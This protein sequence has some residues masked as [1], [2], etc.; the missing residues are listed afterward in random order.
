MCS[1]SFRMKVR[2]FASVVLG[3][4]DEAIEQRIAGCRV[5]A[6]LVSLLSLSGGRI[7]GHANGPRALLI[8]R[9]EISHNGHGESLGRDKMG[10]FDLYVEGMNGRAK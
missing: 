9:H 6:A 2:A 8:A 3:L 5:R 7:L 10:E 1:R 4:A